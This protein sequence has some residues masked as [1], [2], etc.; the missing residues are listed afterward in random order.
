M[1]LAMDCLYHAE[2]GWVKKTGDD[3]VLIG[4][5]NFAQDTLGDIVDVSLPFVGSTIALSVSITSIY[6]R[7]PE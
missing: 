6:W 1:S 3:E 7:Q 4:V 2:H 5:S